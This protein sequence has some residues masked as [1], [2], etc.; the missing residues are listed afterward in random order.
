M[1]EVTK[2]KKLLSITAALA[3]A[4]GGYFYG[5]QDSEPGGTPS[6]QAQQTATT[7]PSQGAPTDPQAVLAWSAL[8]DETGEYAAAAMYTAV[9]DKYGQVEPYVSILAA[10]Q[11]HINALVRQLATYGITAPPNPYL[12]NVSAPND[13]TEA[14][15]AW[16]VGEIDNVQLYDELL[17]KSTDANLVK[18]FNNLRSASL[19]M[20]LPLFE[21]AAQNG[22][23][24]SADQMSQNLHG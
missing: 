15:Q 11:R 22:G 19:D 23:Q 3:V 21:L 6:S 14:A 9:I 10:E 12:G 24:L 13:L 18:V 5:A 17:A 8:M 4:I 16:A 7:V 1:K 20:H 2:M